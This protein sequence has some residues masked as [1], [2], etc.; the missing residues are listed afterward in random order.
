MSSTPRGTLSSP[1][2][3]LVDGFSRRL[4]SS[5]RDNTSWTT[6]LWSSLRS[7]AE[8]RPLVV[9]EGPRPQPTISIPSATARNGEGHQSPDACLRQAL[10]R[11]IAFA[12]AHASAVT[13]S[14]NSRG[15]GPTHARDGPGGASL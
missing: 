1:G 15:I 14:W 10:E 13:A 6:L 7:P 4:W 3:D 2:A 12:A 5:N 11:G 9:V 8:L